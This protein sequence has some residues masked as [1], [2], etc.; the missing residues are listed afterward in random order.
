MSYISNFYQS[1]FRNDA[2]PHARGHNMVIG[3]D[4]HVNAA[5]RDGEQLYWAAKSGEIDRIKDLAQGG[6]PINYVANFAS[7][8]PLMAAS[9]EGHCIAVEYLLEK[10]AH[11][12]FVDSDH[13]SAL[14][15]AAQRGQLDVMKRLAKANAD[16][17]H[18]NVH[19]ET[20]LLYATC[21][22]YESVVEWLLANGANVDHVATYGKTALH[23]AYC[24]EM[25]RILLAN[26]A[27]PNQ[28]T[29]NGETALHH[30]VCGHAT[31]FGHFE[32]VAMVL[33]EYKADVNHASKDGLS[34]LLAASG[35]RVHTMTK[36]LLANGADA[37]IE[38][39]VGGRN[40][41]PLTLAQARAAE[42]VVEILSRY[43]ANPD[44]WV[45][46]PQVVVFF[47][48]ALH[49]QWTTL[50]RLWSMRLDGS[51]NAL[52]LLP[53]ELLHSLLSDLWRIH[54]FE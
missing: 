44:S 24:G 12:D 10:N 3:A 42:D 36:L 20:A 34:S 13:N 19:G 35:A 14:T 53:I 50:A 43:Q 23:S 39:H 54:V 31:S 47:P 46:D 16:V 51:T 30:A 17:N 33:L 29:P 18:A 38:M 21:R 28:T 2:D 37:T 1:L 6:T 45:F 49:Q 4:V 25:A 32:E 48:K 40:H 26:N 27:D 15:I 41:T 7:Q 8:T 22:G 11:V 5:R 52:A 9:G